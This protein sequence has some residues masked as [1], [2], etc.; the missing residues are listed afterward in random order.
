M[1]EDFKELLSIFNA[2]SVKYLIVGGYAVS[3]YAQPRATK[4]IDLLIKPD[5]ENANAVYTALAKFGAPLEGL[6]AE[7][8]IDHG[9]FFR[10]GSEPVMVDLLPEIA[11]V[12][13]DGAWERR[14]ESVIDLKTGLKAC[15]ISRPDLVTAKLAAGRP[16]DLA[17][18]DALRTGSE[19][20]STDQ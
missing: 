20:G 1:F 6:T 14:V 16:Q 10:M 18:V 15:F 8:F 12:D 9:K 4:D 13:F 7:D 19:T 2:H 3:L 17:D 5:A 11:G